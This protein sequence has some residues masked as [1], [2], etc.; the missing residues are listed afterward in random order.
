MKSGTL[1][2]TAITVILL[3]SCTHSDDSISASGVFESR[4]VILSSQ[5]S[6]EILQMNMHEGDLVESGQVLG[7]IDSVQLELKKEQ[8]L[9][10]IE[11]AETRRPHIDVQ[12]APLQQ[13]LASAEREKQRIDNLIKAGATGEKQHDDIVAQIRLMEKQ[14]AA[15]RSSLEQSNLLITGEIES[16]EVQL[17]QIDDQIKRCTLISPIAG[18]VLAKYAERGELAVP[19]K[20]LLKIAD[21]KEMTLRAYISSDQLTTMKLGQVVEVVADFGEKEN[22]KYSGIVKWISDKAEFTPKTIQTR[23]ERS[24]LVYAV[25]IALEND[26]YLKVGMYGG[27]NIQ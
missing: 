19:G 15:R 1:I 14:L 18:T 5:S 22:R 4:E 11:V 21:M 2:L 17:K 25:K 24:N 26:G 7:I 8:L 9:K 13:Q 10:S 23:D 3:A 16:L 6:G 27:I 12:L 20:A